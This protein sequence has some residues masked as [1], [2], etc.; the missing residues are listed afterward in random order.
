MKSIENYKEE[1]LKMYRQVKKDPP[2]I[3][4]A[5]SPQPPLPTTDGI[6]GLLVQVT[7]LK[8]L[9]AVPNARVRVLKDGEVIDTDTT[10]ESGRTKVFSLSAPSKDYSETAGSTV[11]PYAVYEVEVMADGFVENVTI[12]VPV[13]STVTS[14]QPVDL[15]LLSASENDSPQINDGAGDYQ[16]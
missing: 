13:F 14:V 15:L 8:Y 11:L 9:Y 12:S 2:T 7:T 4:T 5:I 3:P 10:D 16:L 6:G 1:M